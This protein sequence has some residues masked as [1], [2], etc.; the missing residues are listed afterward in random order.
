V[1][2]AKS[3]PPL[4]RAKR[5]TL[6]PDQRNPSVPMLVFGHWVRH[7]GVWHKVYDVAIP[8]GRLGVSREVVPRGRFSRYA[9]RDMMLPEELR[10][11]R[12]SQCPLWTASYPTRGP[13]TLGDEYALYDDFKFKDLPQEPFQWQRMATTLSPVSVSFT[14]CSGRRTHWGDHRQAAA[15][16]CGGG[17]PGGRDDHAGHG[18]R[19]R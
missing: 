11:C 7:E 2:S 19:L 5:D 1:L 8:N 16:H 3:V 17:N 13:V 9:N 4:G 10:S 14:E 6:R 18:D 12:V 15:I